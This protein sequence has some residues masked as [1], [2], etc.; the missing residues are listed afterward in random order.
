M[1][2][3]SRDNG[4]LLTDDVGRPL[5]FPAPGG[6]LQVG[7]SIVSLGGNMELRREQDQFRILHWHIASDDVKRFSFR[8]S[9]DGRMPLAWIENLAGHRI[10]LQY[11]ARSRPI[12]I[13]QGAEQRVFELTYNAHDLITEVHFVGDQGQR[14]LMVRYAYDPS[15]RLVSSWDAMGSESTY[16][17][18]TQ[19]RLVA[20]S[21]PL[22]SVFRFR[23]DNDGRCIYASGTDRY[24]ERKLQY[25][26]APRMTKVTNS[27]GRTTRYYLNSGG[28]VIQQISPL[29]ATT[30]TDFDEY[31]RI[32]KIVQPDGG[33]V[34][35]EYDNRGNRRT[36]LDE[37]GGKSTL[38]HNDLHLI[39]EFVDPMGSKWTYDYDQRGNLISLTN[40]LGY[41]LQCTR[42]DRGL[43]TE[44]RRPGGLVTRRR[45]DERLR[46]MELTDQISL[47]IR[48]DVNDLG[49]QTALYDAKGLVRQLKND[50][51]GRPVEVIDGQ[52]R[53]THLH[54]N[55]NSDLIQRVFPGNAWERWAYDSVGRIIAHENAV[56]QMR[57]EYDTEDHLTSVVNRAGERLTRTYDDDGRMVAQTFFDGRI[58]RYEYSPQGFR[59]RQTKSDGRTLDFKFDKSGC[60]LARTSSDGLNETFTYNKNAKLILARS[61]DATVELERDA[62]GR[63]FAEVQNGRR[64]ESSF[65]A[66][67]N[68]VSRRLGGIDDAALLMRYDVRGRLT[69]LVDKAGLCQELRWDAGDQLLERR[70]AEGAVERFCYDSARRLQE[71]RL[72]S[73]VAG[74]VFDCRFEYDDRDNVVVREDTFL[75]RTEFR[76][77]A[78]SRLTE[79]RR[80]SR[81][82]ESYEY[83]GNSTLLGS[84]RGP[85][86]ISA[87]G[88]NLTDGQRR[89]EYGPDGC[90]CAIETDAG[91]CGLRHNVDGRLVAVSLPDGRTIRYTY[92]P[93]GRRVLKELDGERVEFVWHSCDLAAELTETASPTTFFHYYQAP[94]A[95]WVA[96]RRQIPVVDQV[97]LPQALLDELGEAIWKPRYDAYGSVTEESGSGWCPFR[98]RGQYHD[99]ETGFYY[100]FY[101][102]YE[103]RLAGYLGP[104]PIGLAGGSNVYAYPR[105]PLLWDDPFG[106]TCSTK[107][108]GQMGE[109]E[110]HAHYTGLGYTLLGSHDAPHGGGSGRPQGIDGVYHNPNGTPPYIIAEAKYGSAGL[111][112][113][114]HS[115]QQMSDHWIDSPIGGHP[116]PSR[117][118]AA[119]GPGHAAAIT[120]APA[121][122]VE[123]QVFQLPAPG[124]SGSGSVT[125]RRP[126]T[127]G[128][129]TQTF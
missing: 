12:R 123:K 15:R 30:T 33:I 106:L 1:R 87:G 51:L 104:D 63:V 39:T 41:R 62:L 114:V 124:T 74:P 21:N 50:T 97:G 66:D 96:G 58:E 83:D 19:H 76:Y 22:G 91:R 109:D 85:R 55:A 77:D 68:R 56:G 111:G 92:D 46:S 47:L 10:S 100:N 37:S 14:K 13:T 38:A 43:V 49:H 79:I 2:L 90:V 18:D 101:R 11:D 6:R 44:S 59:I 80:D 75:G 64:V 103:P 67:N 93:L 28:Q 84:H 102:D 40:P 7:E 72:S 25:L 95:Q 122:S 81:R 29:G 36:F 121:G 73:P 9:D 69:A 125:Q 34:G 26:S 116:G 54:Y 4:F 42:D 112:S 32:T 70:F 78:I 60:M 89:Y 113:T 120:S 3:E 115:G 108:S 52:G 86:A 27:L 110:M 35:Y 53:V 88:R 128:S 65:D 118:E 16:A 5:L 24:M 31:G 98:F 126:Y 23:Y 45:Y 94:L 20:E 127:P 117:L 17:Y 48:L 61:N 119:V 8:L 129:G 82:V 57:F 99:R 71:H 107:H 105:N